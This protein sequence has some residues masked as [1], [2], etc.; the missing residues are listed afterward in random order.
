MHGM[1][2]AI[3]AFMA[4]QRSVIIPMPEPMPEPSMGIILTTI[5]SL[6]ISQ[7]IRHIIGIAIIG[8]PMG[9]MP[10]I[11][12]GIIP[13]II[14]GIMPGVARFR[15]PARISSRDDGRFRR[16]GGHASTTMER[17]PPWSP[18]PDGRSWRQPL[19]RRLLE[20]PGR[21]VALARVGQDHHDELALVLGALRHLERR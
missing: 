9:I 13:P 14:E 5:P 21:E 15:P 12:P 20:E 19:P 3:M 16:R 4:L 11:M 18:V 10:G 17:A 8:M 2:I 7:V 1:P 6:V